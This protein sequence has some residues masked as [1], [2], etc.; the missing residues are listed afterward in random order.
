MVMPGSPAQRLIVGQS[1]LALAV[2]ESA[3]DPVALPL[4]LAQS[5]RRRIGWGVRQAVF[6]RIDRLHLAPDDQMPASR[7]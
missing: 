5:E 7:L 4:H 6:D 1:A 3:L 2:F